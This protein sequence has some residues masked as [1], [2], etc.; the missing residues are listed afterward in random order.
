LGQRGGVAL[1]VGVDEAMEERVVERVQL[2]G[3]TGVVLGP[4]GRLQLGDERVSANER[5]LGRDVA[6]TLEHARERRVVHLH[7][8]LGRS[9]S[10]YRGLAVALSGVAE[11]RHTG[12]LFPIHRAAP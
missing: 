8:Q 9:G 5:V 3:E 10:L 6:R 12:P 1:D 2:R 4:Q 7:D 11:G